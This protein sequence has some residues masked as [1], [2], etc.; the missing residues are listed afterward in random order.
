V[1]TP[2]ESMINKSN[3]V[4]F[5]VEILT[6]FP[7]NHHPSQRFVFVQLKSPMNSNIIKISDH[8]LRYGYFNWTM[9]YRCDSDIVHRGDGKL[10]GKM[11]G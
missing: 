4:V 11:K 9:T 2:D 7:T 1:F 8:R 6:D 5:Y 3:V 10:G